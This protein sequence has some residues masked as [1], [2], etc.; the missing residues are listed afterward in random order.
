M[1]HDEWLAR[2]RKTIGGSDASAIVHLN[3]WCS[4][5]KAWAQKTGRLPEIRD[6]ENMRQ[7]RD[8]ESYVAW[9]WQDET[10]KRVRREN[11]LLY[12]PRYP[13]AH[14]S[15]DRWVVGENAGLECKTTSV[16]NL[17][18]FKAGEFPVQYWA[19]CL[20]YMA[21]TGA[22]KWY[23]AVLVMNQ[24]FYTYEIERS[25][26]VEGEIDAL[27]AKEE[28]FFGYVA[29]D[30][31]PPVDGMPSTADTLQAIYADSNDGSVDLVGCDGLL[32]EYMELKAEAGSISQKME[33]IKQK[34]ME[35]LG[36]SECGI[37]GG[38]LVSWKGQSRSS[39][40]SKRY[41]TDNP[42]LDLSGYWRV[43]HFRKFEIKRRGSDVS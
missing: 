36:N 41:V 16:L 31:P 6:T 8:L 38:Y 18:K 9:R 24:D 5:Y 1:P 43:S 13:F 15:I 34:L 17:K 40:D 32:D 29:T 25:E 33:R 3:Q 30:M 26:T 4:P 19:Q 7:G 20:H 35:D 12:N 42:G 11:A 27:M 21:V 2:R 10:G 28:E 37:C 14:A 22:D 39:F 23:L